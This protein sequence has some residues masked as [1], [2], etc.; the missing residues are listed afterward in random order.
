[1]ILINSNGMVS[2]DLRIIDTSGS[3]DFRQKR[4]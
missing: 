4:I 1:M 2:L 3:L